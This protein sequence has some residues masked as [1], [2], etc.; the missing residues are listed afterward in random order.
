MIGETETLALKMEKPSIGGIQFAAFLVRRCRVE[1]A[2]VRDWTLFV[3]GDETLKGV[4]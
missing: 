2:E 3:F 1:S 4:L